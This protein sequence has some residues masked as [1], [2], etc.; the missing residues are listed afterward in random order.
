RQQGL[1]GQ[2]HCRAPN[3]VGYGSSKVFVSAWKRNKLY[4]I[5]SGVP[6]VADSILLPSKNPEGMCLLNGLLYVTSWDTGASNL[7]VIAP[8][9]NRLIQ[10]I[11]T[12]YK[13]THDVLADKEGMLWVLSGNKEQGVPAALL[14][15]DP[16]TGTVL[17]AFAFPL[18]AE[19]VKLCCNSRKDT[20]YFLGIDYYGNNSYNGVSQMSIGAHQ[21]PATPFIAASGLQYFYGLGIHPSTGNIYVGDPRGF[22]QRGAV[23]VY[24]TAGALQKTMMA[25]VGPNGFLFF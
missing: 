7:L 15:I 2:D 4:V 16:S 10:T 5:D 3:A 8:A 1:G 13:A 24:N 18:T 17:N 20:L 9:T 21:L 11:N 25:G 14:R 6:S 23:L 19:P 22:N 12:G